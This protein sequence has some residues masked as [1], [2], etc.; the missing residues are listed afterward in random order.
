M[1]EQ[2]HLG[3]PSIHVARQLARAVVTKAVK[4][5]PARLWLDTE[6]IF[7]KCLNCLDGQPESHHRNQVLSYMIYGPPR[8]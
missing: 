5:V 3:A 2:M 4:T 8:R 1:T 6:E 7:T